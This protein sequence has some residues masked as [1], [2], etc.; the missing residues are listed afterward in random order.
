MIS[1]IIK[2]QNIEP[3]VKDTLMELERH[4]NL[5]SA[6]KALRRLWSFLTMIFLIL[7][8]LHKLVRGGVGEKH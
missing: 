3:A 5:E 8:R 6:E 4:K 2:G 1:S 7:R